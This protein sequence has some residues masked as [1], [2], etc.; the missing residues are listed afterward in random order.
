MKKIL[1]KKANLQ[2]ILTGVLVLVL[3][4]FLLIM[5][6]IMLD[7]LLLD[8][9]ETQSTVSNETLSTVAGNSTQTVANA[10]ACG[11]N[12]FDVLYTTNATDGVIINSGNYTV[13]NRQGTLTIGATPHGFEGEDW[14]ISYT[15]RSGAG[16]EVCSATNQTIVAQGEFADYIDLIVLAIVISVV[17]GLLLIVFSLKRVR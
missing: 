10:G 8:V 2:L 6:L 15:Y 12:S 1:N 17:I 4:G 5:G 3:A 11:F 7:E 13:D 14:N 9:S 16:T